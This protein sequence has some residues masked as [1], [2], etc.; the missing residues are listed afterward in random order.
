MSLA[1]GQL[2]HNN[3]YRILAL[4][5]QGGMGAVYQAWDESL[6]IYVA[7][8]ENLD[9]APEAQR[10]FSHEARILARLS[11]PNLPRVIDY[12]FVA[13][14]GQ[15]LVMDYIEGE[16]LGALLARLG[17]LPESDVLNWIAQVCDALVYLHSQPSP[18]IHRDIKPTNIKIRSDRTAVLVDFGIA[19]VYDPVLGT[20]VGAKAVTPGY[21]PPEQY[22]SGTTDVRSDIYALG[23]TL[24]HLLTGQAPPESIQRLVN[25]VVLPSPRQYNAHISP[26]VEQTI[27]R[28]TEITTNRRFQSVA[29][30]RDALVQSLSVTETQ[31][32]IEPPARPPRGGISPWGRLIGGS[33]LLLVI[34]IGG[35]ALTRRMRSET[36]ADTSSSAR[37]TTLTATTL[38]S[39]ATPSDVQLVSTAAALT[40]TAAL[41]TVPPSV[42]PP[43]TSTPLLST[44]TP[45]CPAVNGL[46]AG[47]W[48]QVQDTLGCALGNPGQGLVVEENFVGGKMIWREPVD[49]GQALVIFNDGTW[50]IFQ[51]AP[52][53]EGSAE[54]SCVDENTPAQSPPTPRRGFGMMWCDIPAIR[55][56]LGNAIDTERSYTGALQSF[57]RGFVLRTDYGATFVFYDTGQWEQ[58]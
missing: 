22:G 32:A 38:V 35:W 36:A 13:D 10:Q 46:F 53:V 30:F 42:T 18:I 24:Y 2:L 7:I 1:P 15:Y 11:H 23:A 29:E 28:A 41:P 4:L 50:Q 39:S 55:S 6:Q 51:H 56:G 5:G 34:V 16:D 58:W 21:S 31:V 48:S 25:G 40:L 27:Y 3:R 8:K 57:D 20:T 33:V 14:Q 26:L 9:A 47:V 12:F 45:S 37:L 17:T 52:Y 43:P 54:Y 44:A 19:K 49:E